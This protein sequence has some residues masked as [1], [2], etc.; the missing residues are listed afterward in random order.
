M[1]IQVGLTLGG[2]EVG[3]LAG[4]DGGQVCWVMAE[5]VSGFGGQ[6]RR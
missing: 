2:G 5:V 3:W 1:D 4:E 6:K